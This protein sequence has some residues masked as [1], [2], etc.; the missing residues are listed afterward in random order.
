MPE[1][2]LKVLANRLDRT[3]RIVYSLRTLKPLL[4][5]EQSG[6]VS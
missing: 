6:S 3:V 1:G 5:A 2:T 4:G